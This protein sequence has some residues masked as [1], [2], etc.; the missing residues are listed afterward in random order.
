MKICFVGTG[1]SGTTLI[2]DMFG[3]HPDLLMYTESY[4]HPILFERFGMRAISAHEQ[5]RVVREVTFPVPK[6]RKW[7][8]RHKRTIAKHPVI[9]ITLA[10]YD[11]NP[12]EI[13]EELLAHKGIARTPQLR[14]LF[15]LVLA[16][17]DKDKDEV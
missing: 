10:R 2:C 3:D 5:L 14:G 9:E 15:D 13:F 16:Q 12:H 1:R 8:R 4:W 11:L 7:Y 17:V 6:K